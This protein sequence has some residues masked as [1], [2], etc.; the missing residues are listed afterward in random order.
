MK[1]PKKVKQ[2]KKNKA[3]GARFE[4]KVRHDLESK[5]WIVSKWMNNIEFPKGISLLNNKKLDINK[6]PTM[7][8][9]AGKLIPAKH[10]FC[11]IGRPMA[12]G[13]GFPD[14]MAFRQHREPYYLDNND[15]YLFGVVGVEAKSNGYL[16]KKEKEKVKWLLENNIFSKILVAKKGKKR[17]EIEYVEQSL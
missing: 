2:G 6:F 12:I 14:F 15:G 4:L 7:R 11:G 16:D 13:T 9:E 10:K 1:D 8:F 17:G 5:G 3:A